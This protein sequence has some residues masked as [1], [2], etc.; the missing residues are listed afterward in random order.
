MKLS[1]GYPDQLSELQML[2]AAVQKPSATRERRQPV[3]L[4]GQLDQ[5][6]QTVAS[7]HVDQRIQQYLLQLAAVTRGHSQINLGI[8]PRGVLIWQ[9]ASQAHAFLAG[10]TFVTPDDVQATA[11]P[12]LRVRLGVDHGDATP[13]AEEILS[14][15]P[16]PDYV[17][18]RSAGTV[19]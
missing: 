6:Q 11:L 7:L 12:V 10:R 1:I 17:R 16:I 4:P 18:P 9:R 19:S 14:S 2:G 13:L 8:S 3:F 15:Q 5:L